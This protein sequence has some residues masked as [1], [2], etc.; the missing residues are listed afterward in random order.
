[1]VAEQAGA[2]DHAEAARRDLRQSVTARG[3]GDGG[4]AARPRRSPAARASG[5]PVAAFTTVPRTPVLSPPCATRA[6]GAS[7]RTA[8]R[9]ADHQRARG[10]TGSSRGGTGTRRGSD[11]GA[12]R[13]VARPVAQRRARE[14]GRVGAGRRGGGA[15][16]REQD[17]AA[18]HDVAEQRDVHEDGVGLPVRLIDPAP[19]LAHPPARLH[20]QFHR[21]E[22]A[23]ATEP[24]EVDERQRCV[25]HLREDVASA[26]RVV[27][28]GAAVARRMRRRWPRRGRRRGSW[29]R[30]EARSSSARSSVGRREMRPATQGWPRAVDGRCPVRPTS[31]AA[32]HP[33]TR[34]STRSEPSCA[35]PS[36]ASAPSAPPMARHLAAPPFRA[37][38][39][40]PHGGARARASPAGTGRAR[41]RTRRP[42]PR[43]GP[44]S[45]SPACRPRA[46][47]RRCS[48]APTGCWPALAPGTLLV[49]CTSGDPATSRR[50]AARLAER[51]V[52]LHR[53]AGE[54]RRGRR[55]EAARSP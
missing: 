3:M 29:K 19:D 27:R 10:V 2:D 35:S 45:S 40:E 36:S 31:R 53:R 49:D 48:T 21:G 12:R 38:R 16:A 42:T 6:A 39:V 9:A 47:S 14:I 23:R 33:S 5:S 44:T 30:G 32:R 52:A 11:R 54:R 46:R 22:R 24:D 1:M 4:G 26:E 7:S 50:I 34:P 41:R 20:R 17:A 13:H 37:H 18:L 8:T 15:R 25:V 51:G 43:A 55:R 28:P